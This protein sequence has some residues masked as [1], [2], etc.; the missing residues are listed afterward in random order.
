M[1]RAK[2]KRAKAKR[3]NFEAPT[4]EAMERAAALSNEAAAT[5]QANTAAVLKKSAGCL[6]AK[7]QAPRKDAS[8]IEVT[9]EMIDYES[10]ESASVDETRA[11]LH[12]LEKGA[13]SAFSPGSSGR[14]TYNLRTQL[15]FVHY[16]GEIL[17]RGYIS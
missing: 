3:S 13:S 4:D 14:T 15:P 7:A 9:A 10:I 11:V 12:S 16:F 2:G 6:A 8:N 1:V 5:T 17:A